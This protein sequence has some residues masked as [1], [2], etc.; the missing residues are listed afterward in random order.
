MNPWK[1]SRGLLGAALHDASRVA[2]AVIGKRSIGLQPITHYHPAL[3][4]RLPDEGRQAVARPIGDLLHANVSDPFTSNLGGNDHQR[5][6][7]DVPT[8]SALFDP[9]DKRLVDLDF[10]CERLTA[11]PHHRTPQFVQPGPRRLV[12]ADS[13]HAVQADGTR[14]VLLPDDP[15]HRLEPEPERLPSV[16]KDGAGGDG[17]RGFACATPKELVRREPCVGAPAVRASKALGPPQLHQVVSTGLLREELAVKCGCRSRV[18]H[19][20]QSTTHGGNSSQGN[21]PQP[22]IDR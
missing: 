1:K 4:D 21:T 12:A 8:P 19:G 9:A 22:L 13:Q 14:P 6:V 2:I 3:L 17:H 7:S 5:L 20:P 18:L 16:L 10:A 11:R 15:P